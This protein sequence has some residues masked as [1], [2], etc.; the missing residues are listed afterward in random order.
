M[1]TEKRETERLD[2][3][4][5]LRGEVMVFQPTTI[6]QVSRGGLLV[7]TAFPLQLDSLHD[8]RLT[9]GD[10]SLVVKGRVV[11]SRICDVDQDLVTYQSGIEL[12]EPTSRVIDAIDA[13]IEAARA[14]RRP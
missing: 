7:E 3:L 11:H 9:L 5:T 6:R 12:V 1:P 8:F 10:L 2:L 13:F 4:G 14:A